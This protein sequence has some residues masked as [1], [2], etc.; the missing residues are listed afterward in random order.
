[1][2]P[3]RKVRET[4]HDRDLS[5]LVTGG[6]DCRWAT[7]VIFCD[8][9]ASKFTQIEKWAEA[10]VQFLLSFLVNLFA[11]V[12]FVLVINHMVWGLA[13]LGHGVYIMTTR[14]K[15]VEVLAL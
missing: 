15:S 13:V 8:V 2:L 10:W 7:L 1:L 3:C 6:E 11:A 12:L 14:K 4:D 9:C 5:P